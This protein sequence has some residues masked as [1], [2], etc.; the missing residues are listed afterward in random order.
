MIRIFPKK[1][2]F[3]LAEPD[4]EIDRRCYKYYEVYKRIFWRIYKKIG[5]IAMDEVYKC[6]S[7]SKLLTSKFTNKEILCSN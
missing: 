3:Y 2:T 4:N 6:E 7:V 1:K 5:V